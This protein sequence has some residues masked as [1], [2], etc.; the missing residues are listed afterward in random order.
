MSSTLASKQI[1]G[2]LGL[3]DLSTAAATAI[4]KSCS[5]LNSKKAAASNFK[6]V[7]GGATH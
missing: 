1:P 2:G 6:S 4:F 5:D 7:G 3:R